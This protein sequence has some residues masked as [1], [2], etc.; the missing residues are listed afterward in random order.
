MIPH[1]ITASKAFKMKKVWIDTE[2]LTSVL[3]HTWCIRGAD[4]VYCLQL[5]TSLEDFL[6]QPAPNERVEFV[7]DTF[8]FR[9]T[10]L[11]LVPNDILVVESS[12][13]T[14]SVSIPIAAQRRSVRNTSGVVGVSYISRT[15]RWRATIRR[16]GQTVTV[17]SFKKKEHAMMARTAALSGEIEFSEEDDGDMDSN[18]SDV[19][20][21]SLQSNTNFDDAIS[22]DSDAR[23]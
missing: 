14:T 8:D 18:M 5:K 19:E 1:W 11:R 16:N 23:E 3:A 22:L 17:G 13:S 20:N 2:D 12:Q 7:K 6:M 9:Q 4:V 15:S 21:A 10:N